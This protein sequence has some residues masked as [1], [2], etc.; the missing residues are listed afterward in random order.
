MKPDRV[1]RRQKAFWKFTINFHIII[2]IFF[3]RLPAG[4]PS[5]YFYSVIR[6]FFFFLSPYDPPYYYYTPTHTRL[7][8][9]RDNIRAHAGTRNNRRY[10]FI[11]TRKTITMSSYVLV[12]TARIVTHSPCLD[13]VTILFRTRVFNYFF[14]S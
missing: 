13:T 9:Y 12:Y 14:V 5:R 10:T 11:I 8:I 6:Q 2:I 4:L 1:R 3:S 7:A